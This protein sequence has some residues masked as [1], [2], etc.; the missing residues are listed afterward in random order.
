MLKSLQIAIFLVF[1]V[2]HISELASRR[3]R[4]FLCQLDDQTLIKGI[5]KKSVSKFRHEDFITQKACEL[6]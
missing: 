1:G 2:S 3:V 4:K 5:E 6:L